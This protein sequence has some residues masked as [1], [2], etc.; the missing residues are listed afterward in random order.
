[1]DDSRLRIGT[2][3]GGLGWIGQ[4]RFNFVKM[5]RC[6]LSRSSVKFIWLISIRWLEMLICEQKTNPGAC[7]EKGQSRV[8]LNAT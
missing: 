5:Y 2:E 8:G 3:D 7:P 1:M 6:D 4:S